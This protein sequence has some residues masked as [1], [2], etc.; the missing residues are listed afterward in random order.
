MSPDSLNIAILVFREG[1]ETVL[2]LSA[3]TASLSGAKAKFRR[4]I[5]AGVVI[6]SLATALTWLIAVRIVDALGDNVPAL[7]LQAA[8]GLL[9][10]VVLLLVMNWFF[11]RTYW[12][13]WITLHTNRR[14]ALVPERG[15]V[16]LPSRRLWIGLMLLGFSS[17]YREGFEVVL[18]LQS[19]RLRLGPTPVGHGA[20][21]GSIGVVAVALL[22]FVA[23]RRLPYRKMLIAT[24]V[25]LGFV[26]FVMVGEQA[27]E[28]QLAHWLPTSTLPSL[29][30][31]FPDWAGLWL[32]LFPTVETLAAQGVAV[33]LVLAS[34]GLARRGQRP[35]ARR[36][37]SLR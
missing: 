33:S 27:Q 19:Y 25:L 23:H 12:A 11:H 32:S 18:F 21:V 10:V 31:W 3:V 5:A 7:Q 2:V 35:S 15:D 13:G 24:G 16:T 26:L 22:T 4:P 17:F 1:L 14:R 30:P 28:M 20:I 9:A 34:Y 37:S 6:G 8:T 29:V 36:S